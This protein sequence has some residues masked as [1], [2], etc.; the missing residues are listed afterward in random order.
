[1]RTSFD[2]T[3]SHFWGFQNHGIQPDIA[4]MAKGIRNGFPLAAVITTQ[5]IAAS[6]TKAL[7]F[8]TFRNSLSSAVGS[9]VLDIIEEEKLK[10][11]PDSWN[12]VVDKV[13]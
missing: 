6:L 11:L 1:M 3:E 2:Q 5:S 13:S 4:T 8:N 12:T 9:T 7:H 10:K